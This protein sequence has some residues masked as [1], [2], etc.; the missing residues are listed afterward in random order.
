MSTTGREY[1]LFVQ[2]LIQALLNSEEIL[3]HKNITVEQDKKIPDTNGNI[4]QFDI[5]WEYELAGVTYKTIIECKDYKSKVGVDKVDA[6]VGKLQNFKDIKGLIATKGGFQSG[7]RKSA[8]ANKI[9]LLIIR[10]HEEKDWINASGERII[11]KAT[12]RA[13]V[14]HPIRI[15]NFAPGIDRKWLENENKINEH[16]EF[17]DRWRSD[18]VY[19]NEISEGNK[20]SY[21]DIVNGKIFSRGE[22][23]GIY[24]K[25]KKFN[26]AFLETPAYKHKIKKLTIEYEVK[27]PLIFGNTIDFEDYVLGVIEYLASG[28]KKIVTRPPQ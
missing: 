20:Y 22:A 11:T 19:I 14:Y 26:D 3:S 9:D 4:R 2:N 13:Q 6:L 24:L 23:P 21:Q 10:P 17:D 1:E 7:A 5:Y 16:T 18:E 27:P 15:I 12:I 25:E 28:K 8:D